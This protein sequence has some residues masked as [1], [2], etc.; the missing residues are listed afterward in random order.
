MTRMTPQ[1][2]C[3]AHTDLPMSECW[4]TT[5]N[6]TE[7]GSLSSMAQILI[8]TAW[9]WPSCLNVIRLLLSL[10]LMTAWPGSTPDSSAFFLVSAVDGTFLTR[11][12]DSAMPDTKLAIL[13]VFEQ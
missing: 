3:S 1:R 2:F 10:S 13:F 12:I 4:Q 8:G 5:T 11:T 7:V 9:S 6:L